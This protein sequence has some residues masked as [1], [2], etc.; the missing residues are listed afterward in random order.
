MGL[1]NFYSDKDNGGGRTQL[2]YSSRSTGCSCCSCGLKS[3]DEV[4]KAAIDS[5]VQILK[6]TE[7]FKFENL[8]S[9]ARKKLH[10]EREEFKKRQRK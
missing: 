5:L 1:D 3:E 8:V 7:F 4:R 10:E 9:D 6:A 2:G